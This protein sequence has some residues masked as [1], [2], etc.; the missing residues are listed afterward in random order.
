MKKDREKLGE[1]TKVWEDCGRKT[2]GLNMLEKYYE[3]R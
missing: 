1:T 3:Y 2:R